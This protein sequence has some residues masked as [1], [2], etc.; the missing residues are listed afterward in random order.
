MLI[1]QGWTGDFWFDGIYSPWKF[2]RIIL[3][4]YVFF[5]N[6][7]TR[8]CKN[9]T[10]KRVW[11]HIL[12]CHFPQTTFLSVKSFYVYRSQVVIYFF[13]TM[14][15]Q[16]KSQ[17]AFFWTTNPKPPGPKP[18]SQTISWNRAATRPWFF[19]NSNPQHTIPHPCEDC[20]FPLFAYM[21]GWFLMVNLKV[22]I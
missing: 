7:P 18:T 10:Q 9:R 11:E 5:Q 13:W 4:K 22:C 8:K 1:F 20:T 14:N 16:P 6:I 2:H 17:V 12:R 19:S 15:S 3:R 21:N